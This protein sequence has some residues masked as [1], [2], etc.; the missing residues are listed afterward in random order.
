MKK[1]HSLVLAALASL[2]LSLPSIAADE[3]APAPAPVAKKKV[4]DGEGSLNPWVDCGIGAMLFDETKWAAVT[5]NIIWDW[6]ITATTSAVS[7]RHTCE[8]KQ[9]MAALFIDR[10]FAQIEEQTVIGRGEHLAAML[11]TVGCDAGS[12]D[13]I[14]QSM[15]SEFANVV[16]DPSYATKSRSDK[17]Q[18]YYF[19]LDQ[20]VRGEFAAQCKVA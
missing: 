8:G 9:V 2:S 12:H 4:S 14:V 20:R 6:G 17:A 18:Q 11:D 16:A 13:A 1:T 3:A 15:R 7:S 19:M 5:S 10:T